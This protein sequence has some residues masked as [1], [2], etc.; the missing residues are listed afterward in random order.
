MLE[1]DKQLGRCWQ[2]EGRRASP[3][4]Q[5]HAASQGIKLTEVVNNTCLIFSLN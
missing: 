4:G 3:A 5:I 2:C 1:K